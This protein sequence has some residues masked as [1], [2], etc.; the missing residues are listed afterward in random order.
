M[1]K[2]TTLYLIRHAQSYP[3]SG[4]ADSEWP[5]S[6]TGVRQANALVPLL[7]LLGI[8]EVFT[9]PYR[10]CIE[11]IHPFCDYS[12]KAFRHEDGLR[13][14]KITPGWVPNFSEIWRRSWED[15]SFA[16]PGCEDSLSCRARILGA[17]TK[18]AK[19][20]EG[21]TIAVCGHGSALAIFVNSIA[22]EFGF[23]EACALRNPEILRIFYAAESFRWDFA[24]R[25]GPDFDRLATDVGQTPEHGWGNSRNSGGT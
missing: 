17:M 2:K 18:I 11:T 10:R 16:L 24:F 1:T 23:K 21:K 3:Q 22:P 25:P 19:S 12:G 8:E 6:E 4:L 9:S 20:V 5:L 7:G 15:F 14:R 13:E